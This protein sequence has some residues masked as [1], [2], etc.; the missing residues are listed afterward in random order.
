M[1]ADMG[2]GA[3]LLFGTLLIAG[4]ISSAVLVSNLDLLKQK[5]TTTSKESKKIMDYDIKFLGAKGEIA[6][7]DPIQIG[8]YYLTIKLAEGSEAKEVDL[9]NMIIKYTNYNRRT[10][11]IA[12]KRYVSRPVFNGY[13]TGCSLTNERVSSETTNFGM[14]EV[15]DPNNVFDSSTCTLIIDNSAVVDIIIS[16]AVTGDRPG[17][18]AKFEVILPNGIIK[19]LD[20]YIPK[21]IKGPVNSLQPLELIQ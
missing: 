14:V 13:T 10:P 4:L 2:I 16:V 1:K 9:R 6:M 20:V 15:S 7:S 11:N 8:R 19:Y 12:V 17:H 5:T 21:D 3:L 18:T